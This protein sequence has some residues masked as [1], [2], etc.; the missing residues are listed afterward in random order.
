L[1]RSCHWSSGAALQD[2][3]LGRVA[4]WGLVGG[5]AI[6][7]LG[8]N[9]NMGWVTGPMGAFLA[10]ASVAAARERALRGAEPP[11]SSSDQ[12]YR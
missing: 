7:L 4:L 6:A 12:G 3:S 8:A 2:L 9:A 10:T 11:A 1:P 5:V